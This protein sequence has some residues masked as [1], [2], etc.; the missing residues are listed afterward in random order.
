[1]LF[2]TQFE[3]ASSMLRFQ[4]HY[5]SPFFKD[6]I[7]TLEEYKRWYLENSP[8]GKKTGKF[9]YYTDWSG[10]N[11]PSKIFLPFYNGKFDPLSSSEKEVLNMF[12]ENRH[13]YYVISTFRNNPNL[14]E[15]LNH[16]IAH[17]LFCTDNLYHEAVLGVLNSANISEFKNELRALGGYHED[18]L[19]DEVHAYILDYDGKKDENILFFHLMEKLFPLFQDA[20]KRN[21]IPFSSLTKKV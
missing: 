3:V 20:L 17:G 5:E 7:F 10:F 6:K 19:L 21:N 18:V 12:K 9:T 8:K 13:P 2:N 15:I 11:F 16:E 4:E 14:N 1:M